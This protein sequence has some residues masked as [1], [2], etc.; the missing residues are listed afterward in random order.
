MIRVFTTW[1]RIPAW[2]CEFEVVGDGKVSFGGLV[3]AYKRNGKIIAKLLCGKSILK[4]NGVVG[5]IFPK[6]SC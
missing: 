6:F 3:V 2:F 5:S 1:S 4:I